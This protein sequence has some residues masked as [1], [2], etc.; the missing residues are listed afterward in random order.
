MTHR[1]TQFLSGMKS[2]V[3]TLAF[4]KEDRTKKDN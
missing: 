1:Q 3:V 2:A 4:K